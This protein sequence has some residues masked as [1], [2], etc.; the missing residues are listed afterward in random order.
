MP[1][2]VISNK[3]WSVGNKTPIY[4][5]DGKITG[6][7]GYVYTQTPWFGGYFGK[8]KFSGIKVYC[9]VKN[10]SDCTIDS[11]N[12]WSSKEYD[13]GVLIHNKNKNE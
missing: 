6:Y 9:G 12:M 5:K 7:E 3:L 4:N 13:M 10:N 1:K 8:V 11:D 2:T